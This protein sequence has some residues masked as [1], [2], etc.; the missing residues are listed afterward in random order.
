MIWVDLMNYIPNTK[1]DRREMLSFLGLKTEGDLFK[2][3]PASDGA[4]KVPDIPPA[5]D[6]PT[7]TRELRSLSEKNEHCGKYISF[8]GGGAYRHFIPSAVKHAVSRAEFLT[9]YTPYQA[10][11]SQGLLQ[12]IYEYQ[13]MICNLTGMEASNASHYDGATALAEAAVVSCNHTGRKK[14]IVAGSVHPNYRQV[15]R[16]YS[17]GGKFIVEEGPVS[18]G[19]SDIRALKERI[20][21]DTA[22]VIVQMPNFFGY[23]EDVFEIS[24][25]AHSNGALF[26][27]SVDPISL[28]MLAKPSEYGADIVTAEGQCL[29]SALNFGGPYLGIFAVKKELVRMIP[30]RIVG[31]TCD[32]NGNRG[33]VLTLQARE[34]HIRREKAPSNICSNQA[35]IA[36]TAA[37]YLS[38][39]GE[40][41]LETIAGSSHSAAMHAYNRL[42][43]LKGFSIPF[44]KK[45]FKEFAVKLPVSAEKAK[46][47][48]LDNGILAGPDLGRFYPELKDHILLCFTEMNTKNEIDRLISVLSDV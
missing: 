33:F 16:T 27:V 22:C 32:H 13:T 45:F 29:G 48:L 41:G 43:R 9:A 36:L 20:S 14:V 37:A 11:M 28:G 7:L 19:N 4:K 24:Q 10:E 34:Q 30:G 35:F 18:A 17:L 6:E 42:S 47:K 15:L 5:A 12:A 21:A 1:S 40:K 2:D 46:K 23:L 8:M 25:M 26:A 3:I 39:V 31:M 38:Y 44:G